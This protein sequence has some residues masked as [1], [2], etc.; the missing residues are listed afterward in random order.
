[1]AASLTGLALHAV[2]LRLGSLFLVQPLVVAGLVLSIVFRAALDR[3]LPSRGTLLWITMTAAGLAVFLAAA[4]STTGSA[5]PDG[6]L[7][8]G[9]FA[10]A[11]LL[12]ALT[13]GVSLR[14]RPAR[15]GLLL[16]ISAGIVFG[17]IAGALKATM[18]AA[19]HGLFTTWPLYTL[20]PLGVTGFLLN[21]RAYHR[22]PLTA[23]LPAQNTLN[24]LVALT[25]GV[26]A[27]HER[28]PDNPAAI[29]AE[30][31]G[32]AVVLTGIVLLTPR[33]VS[34]APPRALEQDA[35]MATP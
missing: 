5:R 25:F 22:A 15:A 10:I 32:L 8:A 21:Q 31:V 17:L 7:A 34:G 30:A 6:R 29:L 33:G 19:G 1:M 16:G 12:A 23:S 20:I 14:A 18:Y 11:A 4:G 9:V 27:F 24:A 28:P 35:S 3:R 26:S 13:W 2:A